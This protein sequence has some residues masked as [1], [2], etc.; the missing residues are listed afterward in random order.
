MANIVF[1]V[2]DRGEGMA[3]VDDS[4][5]SRSDLE[6]EKRFVVDKELARTMACLIVVATSNSN[7]ACLR[8]TGQVQPI[9]EGGLF[10]MKVSYVMNFLSRCWCQPRSVYYLVDVLMSLDTHR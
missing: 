4:T 10:W 3:A 2:I 1:A 9:A 5:G 8:P 7:E 6:E